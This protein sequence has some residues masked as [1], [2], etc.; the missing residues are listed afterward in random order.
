MGKVRNKLIILTRCQCLL[1][2]FYCCKASFP[3]ITF[4]NVLGKTWEIGKPCPIFCGEV[5]R[6][7]QYM[8]HTEYPPFVKRKQILYSLAFPHIVNPPHGANN[9]VY[10]KIVTCRIESP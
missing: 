4:A 6:Y 1:C 8:I 5:T 2:L 9:R 10:D 7:A 3:P